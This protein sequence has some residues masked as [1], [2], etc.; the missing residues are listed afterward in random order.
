VAVDTKPDVSEAPP[1]RRRRRILRTT[2]KAFVTAGVVLLLF[3][4]Y[5]LWGTGLF[6][7]RAQAGFRDEIAREGFPEY[8]ERLIPGGA[9]GFITIPRIDL[10]MAF[11]EGVDTEALKKGPG[12]YPDSPLPGRRGNVA[13]AGHRTTYL[14]PFWSLDEL[15][16]GDRILLETA[17]GRFVYRVRWQKVVSPY[18]VWVVDPTRRPSLTLTTCHPRFSASTRLVIRAVQVGGRAPD[19]GGPNGSGAASATVQGGV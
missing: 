13:I 7:S 10:D 18:D 5:E 8:G 2:G 6:T 1:A 19:G 17:R 16:K 9:V 3:V 11:V 14:H 15:R 4:A 12:H